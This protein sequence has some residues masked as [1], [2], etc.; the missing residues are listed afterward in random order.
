L[1]RRARFAPDD[2]RGAIP[3][4]QDDFSSTIGHGSTP[5]EPARLDVTCGAPFG[6]Q[7]LQC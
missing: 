2:T 5:E 1:S 7:N 3:A 6:L 4:R